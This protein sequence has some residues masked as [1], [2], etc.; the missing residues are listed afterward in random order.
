MKYIAFALAIVVG[1][2][3]MMMVSIIIPK[4]KYL[5]VSLMIFTTML[6]ARVSINFLSMEHYRGPSRGFEITIT[7]IIVMALIL[8]L[9]ATKARQII[10]IPKTF[11]ICLLFFILAV[12]N[13]VISPV[14]IYGYFFLWQIF[15][16]AMLYW[17][18]IN[19]IVTEEG[20]MEILTAIWAG[21]VAIGIFMLLIA[22]KQKYLDGYY[23]IPA[24]FDH[25][26]T[27]PSF[28]IMPLCML[29]IWGMADKRLGFIQYGL[30][31][32]ASLG[33]IFAIFATGSRT[34]YVVAAGSVVAAIMI[35]NLRKR[36]LS[37]DQ[38][39]IRFSTLVIIIA[40][41]IGGL[42]VIDT[43]IYRFLHAPEESEGAR[44]EFNYAAEMMAE[45]KFFGV[46]LNQY[47]YALTNVEKYREHIVIM[48][49]EEEGGVAHHIYLLTAAE[50][51]YTGLAVF[52]L[53]L[54]SIV[55]PIGLN[56]LRWKHLDHLLLLG[57]AVGIIAFLMI[58]FLEWVFRL[59]PV[60]YMFAM[61]SGVGIALVTL[62]RQRRKEAKLQRVSVD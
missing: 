50:M 49:N 53:L 57:L 22:F 26:N 16:A 14:P 45:D 19:L 20:S 27:V 60:I 48:A 40:M 35:V 11:L 33:M 46:G 42:M 61:T 4:I 21:F 2:P 5:L 59:T 37:V 7:D 43:V 28:L 55:I 39:R 38:M 56:G 32:A 29:L 10:W 9:V 54:A 52:I 18:I 13:V 36:R 51:G 6:G 47:S 3:G 17:C 1:I 58:G 30:S 24:L 12:I 44:E 34:G 15:R 41:T 23:R 8:V 31:M 62:D 25:S